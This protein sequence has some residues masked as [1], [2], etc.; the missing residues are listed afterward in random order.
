IYLVTKQFPKEE[1]F[2][3][4][5]QIRR[6]ASTVPTNIVE[7][8]AREYTKEFIQF[9]FIAKGSLIGIKMMLNKLIKSLR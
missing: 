1:L 4:T 8:Q 5:A 3:L 2:G 7:G 6:S 9:L